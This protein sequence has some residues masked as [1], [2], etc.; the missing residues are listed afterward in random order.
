MTK[1]HLGISLAM[2]KPLM[3]VFTK[4]DLA[5][6]GIYKQNL[7][8]MKAI[9]KKV[10]NKVPVSISKF[11]DVEKIVDSISTG[12]V[13]PIFSVSSC[14]GEGIETIRRFMGI[15]KKPQVASIVDEE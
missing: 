8:K 15:M 13:C 4:I 10:C 1:E 12:K 14:T 9:L 3:V 11:E 5:P 2:E 7:D 6:E